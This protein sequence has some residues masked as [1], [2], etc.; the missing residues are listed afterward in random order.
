[1][2]A[3]LQLVGSIP[4]EDSSAVFRAVAQALP[5]LLGRIPDGETGPRSRWNSWTAPT[6]ERTQGL[7]LVPPPPGSYTPWP[8]AQLVIDPDELVLERIGFADAAIASYEV[9]EALCQEGTIAPGTRFQVCLPSPIAPMTVLIAEGSRAAVEP[10]HLRQLH[11]EITEILASVPHD[12]LAIQWDVCQDVGIW[13]GYYSAYFDDVQ[14]GVIDRLATCAD[15]IPNDVQL[16]FHLCYGDFGHKH[17]IDPTDLGVCTEITNR[18]IAAA[19]RTIDYVHVPVPIDRDDDAY[20]APLE[21]LE[22]GPHSD[23]Y[24]GLIHLDDGIE[25]ASRR[26]A[27]ARRH[28]EHFGVATECGFGRRPPETIAPLLALHADVAALLR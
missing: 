26:L 23:L 11:A 4:L 21:A 6:Y 7:E 28:V 16:G 17:F 2:P 18:L 9:F 24:I 25:G 27:T 1:V 19:P 13:E 12:R 10:A 22:L 14:Q 20:L 15:V 8:Q 5:G 3:P